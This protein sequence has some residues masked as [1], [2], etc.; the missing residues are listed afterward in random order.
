MNISSLTWWSNFLGWSAVS[1]T[2]LGAL[3]GILA[4]YFAVQLNAAKDEAYT[5]FK[6]ESSERVASAEAHSSQ[7]NAIAADANARASESAKETARLN[8]K[9]EEER[10]A[11]IEIEERVAAR[12]IPEKH[13]SS[14][15]NELRPFSGQ[16]AS[17]WFQAGDHEARVFASELALTLES[18]QWDV[19]APATVLRMLESGRH[20]PTVFETGVIVLS[21]EDEKSM[22]ASSE[23]VQQLTLLGFDA[24][25]SPTIERRNVPIVII[26]VEARPEGPQGE[27]KLRKET[28]R[29]KTK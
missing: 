28:Q 16:K 11:R 25:K 17:L 19:Y 26:N 15:A 13:R 8:Q 6:A 9:A 5:R 1:L 14:L 2:A 24:R 10:L 22:K 27:A 20:G 4:W 29:G 21:T 12:R 18:A 7:A 23:L 3:T